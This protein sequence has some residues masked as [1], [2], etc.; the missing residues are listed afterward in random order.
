MERHDDMNPTTHTTTGRMERIL[1]LVALLGLLMGSAAC[2]VDLGFD[3]E[4][5]GFEFS[6]QLE[7]IS[8]YDPG[9]MAEGAQMELH[10][11][12]VNFAGTPAHVH[13]TNPE[14]L[15]IERMTSRTSAMLKAKTAGTAAIVVEDLDGNI[16]RL[17]VT[18]API[19]DTIIHVLPWSVHFPLDDN[20]LAGGVA[21]LPEAPVE[22]FVEHFDSEG[23][24]LAGFGASPL[25]LEESM[26]SRLTP[27]EGTDFATLRSGATI[28]SLFLSSGT[29]TQKIDIVDHAEVSRLALYEA[30]KEDHQTVESNQPLRPEAGSDSFMHLAAFVSDGR[31]AIGDGPTIST[32]SVAPGGE[33][34]LEVGFAPQNQEDD[35]AQR[36]LSNARL[37]TLQ[38]K[39]PGTAQMTIQWGDQTETFTVEVTER[40]NDG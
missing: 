7:G 22:I 24:L 33:D 37:F 6:E 39:E 30:L 36:I 28:E 17:E 10:I 8:N 38:T 13:S 15:E 29:E 9:L 27:R 20:L 26:D 16:G 23:R 35:E 3:D 2:G 4:E 1:T 31:Y 25:T 34:V 40:S 21:M 18:V 19:A 12:A 32:V 5:P 14:V 11:R